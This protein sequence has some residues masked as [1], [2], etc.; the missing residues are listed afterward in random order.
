MRYV[1]EDWLTEEGHHLLDVGS[2][3]K[4]VKLA[5]IFGVGGREYVLFLV[6]L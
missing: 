3:L 2:K 5:I 4:I 1:V 6:S